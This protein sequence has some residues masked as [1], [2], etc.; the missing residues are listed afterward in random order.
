MSKEIKSTEDALLL[1]LGKMVKENV[2]LEQRVHQL[3]DDFNDLVRQLRGKGKREG[4]GPTRQTFQMRDYCDKL[5]LENTQLEEYAKVVDSFIK[6]KEIYM[7]RG[8][9]CVYRK[10]HPTVASTYCLECGACL[11]VLEGYG[12]V[13]QHILERAKI[14]FAKP[15]PPKESNS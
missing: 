3:T 8:I 2:E 12:V 5:E 14:G 1:R 15:C 4:E 11:R 6:D 7:P 13:C 10:D 9:Q